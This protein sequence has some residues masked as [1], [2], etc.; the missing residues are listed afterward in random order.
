M[1]PPARPN[2]VRLPSGASVLWDG[3][4]KKAESLVSCMPKIF[5]LPQ[6][7]IQPVIR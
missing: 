7:V 4:I 3:G 2:A 5:A 6:S 1:P